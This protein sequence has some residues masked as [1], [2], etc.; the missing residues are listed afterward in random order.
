MAPLDAA[1]FKVCLIGKKYIYRGWAVLDTSN[2]V[3]YNPN[4]E[5]YLN[6]RFVGNFGFPTLA[7]DNSN[8]KKRFAYLQNGAYEEAKLEGVLKRSSSGT[9]VSS[10]SLDL[11]F[12][13][14]SDGKLSFSLRSPCRGRSE[15]P[16][17]CRCLHRPT[18]TPRSANSA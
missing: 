5:L 4:C 8:R 12:V 14:D 1:C 17:R 2:N 15:R 18:S 6:D 16:P 10:C 3:L 7:T 13:Y 9:E 11:C